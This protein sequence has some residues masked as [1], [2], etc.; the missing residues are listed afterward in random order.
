MA[1]IQEELNCGL[2]VLNLRILDRCGRRGCGGVDVELDVSIV[3][4]SYNAK[5]YLRACLRSIPRSNSPPVRYEVIVVDNASRDGAAEMVAS[6]FAELALL[7]RNK[8]NVGF[9]KACNQGAAASKGRYVLLLNPDMELMAG[10]LYQLVT[11]ADTHPDAGIVGGAAVHPDGSLGHPFARGYLFPKPVRAPSR[12]ERIRGGWL[13][14]GLMLL[15]RE[16]CDQVGWLDEHFF[17]GCEDVEIC[18]RM[19]KAGWGIYYIPYVCAV[20][21]GGMSTLWNPEVVKE[22]ARARRYMVRKH[23]PRWLYPLWSVIAAAE[24]RVYL[25]QMARRLAARRERAQ[26]SS[27]LVRPEG[28]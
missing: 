10:C 7:L 5:E 23:A 19:D 21:Y 22:N 24:E 27:P 28:R 2:T 14:G 1:H 12:V 8:E 9:A 16:A 25:R 3:I 17:F 13:G 15:R 20:H 6:E 4:V 18:W 11:F 26:L